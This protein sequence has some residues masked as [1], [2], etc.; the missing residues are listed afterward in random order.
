MKKTAIA[1]GN[2]I[3]VFLFLGIV[4]AFLLTGCRKQESAAHE[5]EKSEAEAVMEQQPSTGLAYESAADTTVDIKALQKENPDVFAWIYI[6][7]TDID[8]PILQSE[9]AD[10]YYENHNAY[11]E[12]SEQGALYTE[13]ANLKNM[14]DFNTVI[15]GKEDFTDLYL[16]ADP[17]FFEEHE[18]VYIYLD[19]NLLTYT[20]F[21][22]YEREN[23]SLIRTYDFTYISGCQSFLD[24]LYGTR[25]MGMN[26]REG[27]EELT[28]YHFLITLT[29]SNVE[30]PN[31]QFVVVAALV[32]DAAG[33]IDRLVT[34]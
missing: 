9:E 12:V 8:D 15:H 21:A 26:L 20:V 4:S 22:T 18:D 27:W 16:F 14:C 10:D 30:N 6:P 31:R 34:E 1:E 29:I 23:T 25:R 33:T 3:K 32:G 7:G 13:L 19:N 24:D 28:P 2:C 5:E 17:A 11:G